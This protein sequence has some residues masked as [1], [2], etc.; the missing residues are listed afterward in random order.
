VQALDR[1]TFV[2][3]EW[4]DSRYQNQ[5]DMHDGR[6]SQAR[7]LATFDQTN[8]LSRALFARRSLRSGTP[9]HL[10]WSF[11]RVFGQSSAHQLYHSDC[12]R[13][14]LSNLCANLT[15]CVLQQTQQFLQVTETNKQMKAKAQRNSLG[16]LSR[17]AK[18]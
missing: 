4:C 5:T 14:H 3:Q 18:E 9:M 7:T 12:T 6:C 1:L 15:Q 17:W 2:Q 16:A 13:L 8:K 10:A 11:L